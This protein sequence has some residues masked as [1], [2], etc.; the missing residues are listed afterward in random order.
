MSDRIVVMKDGELIQVGTPEEIYNE[1]KSAYV[2]DFI[3]ESNIYNGTMQ[4]GLK[5]RFLGGLWEAVDDFPENEKVDVV[6]RPEDVEMGPPGEGTVDA[7][8]QSRVFKGEDYSYVLSVGKSEVL[9][10]DKHKREVGERVSIRV[11]KENLQIVHKEVTENSWDD[12]TISSPSSVEIGDFSFPCDLTSLLK[13][14]SLDEK[15]RLVDPKTGKVYD[16]DGAP[17]K[18]TASLDAPVVS[19]DLEAG[20]FHGHIVMAVWIGDHYQYLIRSEEEEDVICNSPYQWNVGDEVSVALRPEAVH[21][22]L[23]KD[24]SEYVVE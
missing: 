20:P 11:E 17:V 15:G 10:R 16:L 12:A 13:G 22:R 4:K 18:V 21:L 9:C 19:D 3:G 6:I 24:L 7:T 5:V 23:K 14:S 2:A 1:P 8:V